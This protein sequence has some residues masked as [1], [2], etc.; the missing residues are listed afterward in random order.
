MLLSVEKKRESAGSIDGQLVPYLQS[1]DEARS[2][3]ELN[4]LVQEIAKPLIHQ[5]L[6]RSLR[7]SVTSDEYEHRLRFEDVTGDVVLRVLQRLRALKADPALHQIESFAGLVAMTTY[8]AIADRSRGERRQRAAFNKKIRRL[9]SANKE[10]IIWKDSRNNSICGYRSWRRNEAKSLE[11]Q[12][13]YPTEAELFFL[14]HESV[15]ESGRRNTAEIVLFVLN[16]IGRPLKLNDLFNITSPF[17]EARTIALN[18]SRY[19]HAVPTLAVQWEP[20]TALENRRLLERLFTEIQKLTVE[21][22]KSLLLNMTNSYGYSIEWFLF[23]RIATE[24]QLADLLE[25]SVDGF[26]RLLS[27]LPMTDKEI[28]RHLGLSPKR[29]ANIRK[30]VRD[31]LVRCKRAF[32]EEKSQV[33]RMRLK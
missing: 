21:Q 32:F 27:D 9:F 10:L 2:Q 31:R 1:V 17:V 11:V 28:A 33:N 7:L 23:T 12:R 14:T 15:A 13:T 8:N 19:E 5:I 22:R 29:V 16:K 18:E 20:L 24:E 30:A 6:H 26:R 3:E 4:R 25:I